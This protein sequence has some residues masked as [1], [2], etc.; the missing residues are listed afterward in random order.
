VGP[1]SVESMFDDTL[2]EIDELPGLDDAALIDAA[3][4]W[5]RA[6]NAA[7]ARKQAVMAEVFRRRTG[8]DSAQDRDSWWVDPDA[9]VAAELAAAQGVS[10]GLALAQ[11]H[12]GVAL[13]D[14]LPKIAALFAAGLISDLLVRAIVWRT[15]LILDPHAMAQVDAALAEQ[16][17]AWGPLSVKKAEQAIDALVD[18]FDPGAL[19]RSR[20]ASRNRDV[21]FG[22]P[23]DEPGFTSLWARLYAPDAAVLEQ[24]VDE[25]ARSVCQADPRTIGERRADAMTA[26]AAGHHALACEC[27]DPECPATQT[28]HIPPVT[29]V[30]YVV[31]DATTVTA[32]RNEHAAD[33]T[34]AERDE[35]SA[36]DTTRAQ[37]ARPAHCQPGTPLPAFAIGAGVLP[38][39]L[40][41]G[42]LARA[43]VRQLRHPGDAPPEKSY[44]ASRALDMFVR[45]R[46]LTCRWPG[47]DKPA[48]RCDLDH[49]VPYPLGPTHAS[50]LKCLCRFHHLLKTFWSGPRGWRDRQL[51]DGTVI[52][53]SPTGHQ[54]T[55]RP[56]SALLF[57][58]LC[59]PTGTLWLPEPNRINEAGDRG[60]MMPRREHTRAHNRQQAIAA[61]RRLNDPHVAQ[62]NKPPP[63]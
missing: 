51:P 3:G 6:E 26:L 10:Q 22:S 56:G 31:A 46:D 42:V 5:A 55:T 16:V 61:E 27:S 35:Q 24:R 60:V 7:C 9:A 13:A 59:L 50:N 58:T 63:F 33:K 41:A 32:A 48:D 18:R 40:L 8:L 30:V 12:R 44:V 21:Q 20:A 29:A 53:T 49:T 19:R 14:R 34:G 38:T 11:T 47:C 4:G 57:P 36:T 45:C 62:R 37:A 25:I 28:D 17:T 15:A 54:Y 39:P 23:S 1:I 52:W 2:P 43:T